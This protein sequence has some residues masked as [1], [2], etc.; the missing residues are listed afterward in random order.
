MNKVATVTLT[1][2]LT[3][4]LPHLAWKQPNLTDA[5]LLDE[6]GFTSVSYA[7]VEVITVRAVEAG[8]RAD[9][10]GYIAFDVFAIPNQLTRGQERERIGSF[11]VHPNLLSQ[12]DALRECAKMVVRNYIKGHQP[13]EGGDSNA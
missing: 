3:R 12:V 7:K 8:P 11:A 13:T 6:G 10:K 9:L 2:P 5:T 4:I 1:G